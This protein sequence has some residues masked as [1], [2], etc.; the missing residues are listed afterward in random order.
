[1]ERVL[2]DLASRIEETQA[3]IRVDPLPTI[4]ADEGLLELLFQNLLSNAIKYRKPG[5]AP[6][7]RVIARPTATTQGA[8][9]GWVELTIE[10][11]GIGF[12]PVYAEQIF[13]PF[14]RL[15]GRREYEGSGVGLSICR[16][17]VEQHG[18]TIT[19]D[20][21]PG[22]GA[23]FTVRLRVSHPEGESRR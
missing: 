3:S 11:E 8:K 5:E 15:H 17:V 6:T 21:V 16:R 12:E 13:R 14:E 22:E 9:G 7:I 18:G 23:R 2:G 10:D 4:E 19:A 20:A 1:V